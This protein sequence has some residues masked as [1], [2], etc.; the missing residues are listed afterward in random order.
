MRALHVAG[1]DFLYPSLKQAV[2][3]AVC[4]IHL[5]RPGGRHKL[6]AVKEGGGRYA[7][8]LLAV[9]KLL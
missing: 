9:H 7:V 4:V 1:K 6:Q 5:V 8:F 2:L 3:T